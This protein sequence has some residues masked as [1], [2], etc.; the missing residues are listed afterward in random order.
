M[1][2]IQERLAYDKLLSYLESNKLFTSRQAWYRKGHSTQTALL[3]VLDNI[4]K[5][6]EDC[7]VTLLTLFDFSKAFDCIPH[8]KLLQKLRR[9][10]LSDAA[11]KWLHSYVT[12]RHQTVID[13]SGNFCS[14]YRVSAGVPEGSVLGPLLFALFIN[15]LPDVLILSNHMIYADDTQIYYYFSPPEYNKALP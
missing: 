9:Y 6:V 15:D 2:K 14:W 12:D 13:D 10:N 11:I 4:Q 7:K 5:A 1:A 8:K 3:G